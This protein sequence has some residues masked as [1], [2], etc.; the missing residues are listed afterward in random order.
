MFIQKITKIFTGNL[1][2]TFCIVKTAPIFLLKAI[3]RNLI[4]TFC[5]VKNIQGKVSDSFSK[6]FNRNILYCKG[7]ILAKS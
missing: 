5:I 3:L 7:T 1:I 6:E 2:G 4:G